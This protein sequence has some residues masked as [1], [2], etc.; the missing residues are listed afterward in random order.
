MT[1]IISHASELITG[2]GIRSKKGIRPS[3][4]DLNRI[5]DGALVIHGKKII[6][7]GKTCDLPKKYL[8][9]K[10]IN[11][12]QKKCIV[13]GWI[14][15]HTHLVYAGDR[16]L[17][18]AKRCAGISYQEIA[19]QGGGILTTVRATRE[20]SEDELFKIS[21]KRIETALK[22]GIR[23]IEIKSG[24][25]LTT[26]SELKQLKVAQR[27]KIE[28][29]EMRIQTTF[30]GAHAIPPDQSRES[31]IH[32]IIHEMIPAIQKNKLADACDVFV[33][34]GY[35]TIDECK[36]ILNYATKHGL[37]TKIH[38]DELTNTESASLG[39]RINALSV[40]HLLK[41]SDTSIK[42]LAMS[43]TVAVLL[44]GTAFFLKV[45]YAP[46]RELIDQKVCVALSTDYNPGT[47]PSQNPYFIM[48]LA[49]LHL[50]M[51]PAEI[52]AGFTYNAARALGWEKTTGTLEV[53][54][55][56]SYSI[57][58][59]Q[60]FEESYYRLGWLPTG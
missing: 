54:L 29:P 8:K 1:Q 17:E 15:C 32:Q 48:T 49:A 43:K 35:Y 13:P 40:D 39:A 10:S 7:V 20:I 22:L 24:Y 53:G 46:A 55:N 50:G 2:K 16:S 58:P 57:L 5:P 19:N 38:A 21:K 23:G 44:P 28:F 26:E 56:T 36:I 25:G 11:L 34:E 51:S 41:V 42:A 33:D 47:C 3:E 37:K 6:W 52:F 60:K 9:I 31:Y 4:E 12:K 45:P 18:F 30:L 59:F 27:L 14:D